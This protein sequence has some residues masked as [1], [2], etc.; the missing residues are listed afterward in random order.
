MKE[1]HDYCEV[2]Q[3]INFAKNLILDYE[4]DSDRRIS[5]I[6]RALTMI[7]IVAILLNR[8]YP[9]VCVNLQTDVR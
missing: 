5:A 1:F 2:I 8:E 7:T 4:K 6:C 3:M 9:K